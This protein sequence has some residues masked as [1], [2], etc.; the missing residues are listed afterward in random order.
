M[1][2]EPTD[3]QEF[4]FEFFWN[5]V[6]P[7]TSN[8]GAQLSPI[9]TNFSNELGELGSSCVS[10]APALNQVNP[11]QNLAPSINGDG[12]LL[13]SAQDALNWEPSF[14][15]SSFYSP[16]ENPPLQ[17]AGSLSG[18]EDVNGE[19]ITFLSVV[20]DPILTPILDLETPSFSPPGPPQPFF[21][22]SPSFTLPA[23]ATYPP[24]T[25][26]M[27]LENG[28]IQSFPPEEED[29][30]WMNLDGFNNFQDQ[31]GFQNEILSPQTNQIGV[32]QYGEYLAYD[33]PQT[34]IDQPSFSANQTLIGDGVPPWTN[35][36]QP[37][38]PSLNNTPYM[39]STPLRP[40]QLPNQPQ[41]NQVPGI[42]NFYSP[43]GG[44]P[45]MNPRPQNLPYQF[46]QVPVPT[47]IYDP[48]MLP[49]PS[50]FLRPQT[51]QHQGLQNQDSSASNPNLD[52]SQQT[53]LLSSETHHDQNGILEEHSGGKS[54]IKVGDGKS[55]FE[56]GNGNC[57]E[58]EDTLS[59][60]STSNKRSRVELTTRENNRP[61]SRRQR[62]NW[63]GTQGNQE[64]MSS[65]SVHSNSRVS[66]IT[67]QRTETPTMIHCLK[68]LAYLLTL[69]CE[70]F[71]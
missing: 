63:M 51:G 34:P 27:V 15:S 58:V 49:D 14:S 11:N 55:I 40:Q 66:S 29:V 33:F 69:I 32:D 70:C 48:T 21:P 38:W 24:A 28:L 3:Q 17:A 60:S 23:Q 18:S 35:Q 45:S 46:D 47:S 6:N 37:Y 43:Q 26:E 7:L 36:Q 54:I 20:D 62:V 16:L 67:G 13:D 68:G 71:L 41:Y 31:I 65:V 25:V 1:E 9:P 50:L 10:N 52:A 57:F 30:N 4:S 19:G 8:D 39:P 64:G 61:A 53:Q 56:I 42:E 22:G 5:D 59:S 2:G 12:Q 44:G